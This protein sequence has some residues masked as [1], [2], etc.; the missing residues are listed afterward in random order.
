MNMHMK[1]CVLGHTRVA[2]STVCAQKNCGMELKSHLIPLSS[3][4][5]LSPSVLSFLQHFKFQFIFMF[6]FTRRDIQAHCIHAHNLCVCL[7]LREY[8]SL[9]EDQASSYFLN[10]IPLNF[11]FLHAFII[12]KFFAWCTLLFIV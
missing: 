4:P 6:S 9:W 1:G 5:C 12:T 7:V 11:H 3:V 2:S 8:L 10:V